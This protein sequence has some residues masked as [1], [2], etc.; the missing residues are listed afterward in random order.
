M[1]NNS[2]QEIPAK[3]G[4]RDQGRAPAPVT[5]NASPSAA[6]APAQ[7]FKEALLESLSSQWERFAYY[8]TLCSGQGIALP[9]IKRI[10]A[11]EE[12][13]RIPSVA[14]SA[15][16]LSKGLI[17]ELNDLSAPGVFQVSSST[18]GDPSYVYAD[19]SELDRITDRYRRTFGIAGVRTAVAFAPSIRI[20]RALSKKAAAIIPARGPVSASA[21]VSTREKRPGVLRMLTA[22]EGGVLHYE[23]L[24]FTVDVD[25]VKTLVNR[26]IGRP[27]A[28]RRKPTDSLR[29]IIRAVHAAG[30]SVTLGGVVLLLRPYLDEFREGE[31]SLGALGHVAFSGGGYSGAKG[32]IRGEKIDKPRFISKIAAVF[33]IDERF[34]ST[35]FKDIYG[36]TETS[37]VHEGFWSRD[38]GEFLFCT[39]PGSKLYIVDPGTEVPLRSG[40]GLIKV[41]TP[42]ASGKAS[43]ANVIV[44]QYDEAE[45]VR[46]RD[47]GDVESF[48]RLSRFRGSSVEGCA[49]KAADI[50]GF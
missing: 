34:W 7:A 23:N 31:F 38:L 49:F 14:S 20:L 29:T 47:T 25:I 8:R 45:I 43:A 24:H 48:T 30:E 42:Y 15:F 26:A 10:I 6:L 22:I 12:Y 32:A 5:P 33:G 3:T 40:R 1:M 19:D 9:D 13:H 37:S 4:G 21:P 46:C 27:A 39:D 16:K 2:A 41:I 36:F 18:S 11:D 50:A 35:N 28:V 17:G 44:L